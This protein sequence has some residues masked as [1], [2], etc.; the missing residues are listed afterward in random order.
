MSCNDS[1]SAKQ[2]MCFFLDPETSKDLAFVQ[3][4][5]MFH[6]LS[7]KDIYDS[8]TRTAFT[9]CQKNLKLFTSIHFCVFVLFMNQHNIV[10]SIRQSGRE[11]MD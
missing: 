7:K 8:Q 10:I 3:F 1:S 5:Q 6:N 9:V 11:W 4:P 2:S